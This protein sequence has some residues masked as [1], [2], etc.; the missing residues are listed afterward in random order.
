M[1]TSY[2]PQ[3]I[4][5]NEKQFQLIDSVTGSL[6]TKYV[7]RRIRR[8]LSY[9]VDVDSYILRDD[10]NYVALEQFIK[11]INVALKKANE[12]ELVV[13]EQV[14]NFIQKN[15]YAIR[16]HSIAGQT[17]KQND[18]N[19]QSEIKAFK[20]IVD[21]EMERSLLDKQI[22]SSFFM[23][24]MKKVANFSVP[25]A[26]KTAMTYGAFAYLSSSKIMKVNKILVVSPLNAFEA[27]RREYIEIFGS[28]RYLWY[29]NLRD[30]QYK[31]DMGRIRMDW[32][33]ADLIVVNFESLQKYVDVLNELID[34]QTM[35]VFDEVHR[36][37]GIGGARA[38]AALNLGHNSVYR[39]VL[40]GTPIPNGFRD[41]YNFLHL[42]YNDEY[43]AQFAWNVA[44][45]ENVDA[46]EVN[47]K[48]Y[49]FF[50][51]TN[52]TELGVPKAEDDFIIETEPT[53]EQSE[54]AN[55]I[56]ENEPGIL[57]IYIRLLQASTNPSLVMKKIDYSEM[58]LL[59]DEIE[60]LNLN[61]ALNKA[62]EEIA[63]QM[64]Y[65]KLNVL[66]MQSPKFKKGID[67]IDELVSQG[68][69]VMVWGMFVDT[70]HKIQDALKNRGIQANLI[71]GQTPKEIRP[72][73]IDEFKDE[74]SGIEVM[75]SNPNTLGESISLHQTV[76]D[77]VY[78]EY[79]FNLTF[80][81]QSRDR[82]HRLGLKASQYTRYYYLQSKGDKA[83]RGFIDS[84][85]YTRLKEKEQIMLDAIEGQTLK[86][87]VN[88]D[89]LESIKKIV[90][91]NK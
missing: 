63:R 33:K 74:N 73:L 55:A 12:P 75:I 58:G 48:L 10:L 60:N 49:P 31:S 35:I 88:D 70:M 59:D 5:V 2:N 47:E 20:E 18:E 54:L 86:I 50:W 51:R 44:E 8:Y 89:F 25:G 6:Q 29:M 80:M 15:S 40:T 53:D 76:H 11:D 27:W 7:E 83:H 72:Q 23:S 4:G 14:Q 1:I 34:E 78:F 69:K 30:K 36:I 32:G 62:E 68:K 39:Y 21:I 13:S 56:Y 67:L 64:T 24:T 19:W 57:A 38:Q 79:N 46:E 17:I 90:D 3:I 26:G 84:A 85:V 77:A 71:Y 82:I 66:E 87:E 16:E 22:K 37:K 61:N 65:S 52:K 42:L 41:I 28:K 91:I 45:L 43:D 81:L 9:F